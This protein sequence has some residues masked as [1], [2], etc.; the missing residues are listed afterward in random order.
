MYISCAINVTSWRMPSSGMW[1]RVDLVWTDI[2]EE[3][4]ASIFRVEKSAS[5]EPARA[6][7]CRV[8]RVL[9]K[10]VPRSRNFLPWR[11]RRYVSPKCRFTQDLHGATSHK[12]AFFLVT[13]VKTSHLTNVTLYYL[14]NVL[15]NYKSVTL[16]VNKIYC[17]RN[18]NRKLGKPSRD[19][20]TRQHSL[21]IPE[22]PFTNIAPEVG[23]WGFLVT[24]TKKLKWNRLRPIP[25]RLLQI[26]HAYIDPI[27]QIYI[28]QGSNKSLKINGIVKYVRSQYALI[29]RDVLVSKGL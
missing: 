28:T 10:L 6:S 17:V 26:L 24:Y 16:N 25:C 22:V 7:G 3:R 13:V 18:I 2:S 12:T 4:I 23:H 5:E 19:T 8:W 20:Q 27:T 11:W 15:G 1:R 21:H 29:I 9:L 14:C